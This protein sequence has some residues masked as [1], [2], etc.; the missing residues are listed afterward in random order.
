[1]I[2][3]EKSA[4]KYRVEAKVIIVGYFVYLILLFV[5]ALFI[6]PQYKCVEF[7]TYKYVVSINI[8]K[9]LFSLI[10]SLIIW[11][12]FIR[13]YYIVLD[14][15]GQVLQL[16]VLL[17]YMPGIVIAGALNFEWIYILKYFAYFLVM[18]IADNIIRFPKRPLFIIKVD[19]LFYLKRFVVI[20]SF[21]LPLFLT[22]YF[23]RSFSASTF[24]SMVKNPYGVRIAAR[25]LNTRW[26]ILALEYWGAYFSCFM[27]TYSLKKRKWGLAVAYFVFILFYF[28]L[29]GNRI[30][31]FYLGMAVILGFYEINSL[32]L[33]MCYMFLL[34]AQVLE[35]RLFDINNTVGIITNIFRRYSIVPNI[36]ASQ[37]YDFFKTHPSDWLTDVYV[38]LLSIFDIH[39]QYNNIGFVIGKTYYGWEMSANNGL[40][41]GAIYE[42]GMLGIIIDPIM[43]VLILRLIEKLL[44]RLGK[45]LKFIVAVIYA[46][47]AIN[48][49][50]IWTGMLR[51]TPMLLFILSVMP[52]DKNSILS[53]KNK[54][55]VKLLVV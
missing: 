47:Q 51:L 18:I 50:T 4:Y 17:Y 39:S 35:F 32:K 37:Y 28:T 15:S 16:L 46:S 21:I 1:M 26:A 14:F 8:P 43:F 44:F 30:F 34:V 38:D 9:L 27:V 24:I 55:S 53:N 13:R 22:L 7:T 41:G 49:T 23:S 25:G 20:C 19:G 36:I 11:Y 31:V 54:E 29:Q 42:F 40:F 5:L 12:I 2:Q 6:W 10:L 45:E 48:Q 3:R 33:C 52:F